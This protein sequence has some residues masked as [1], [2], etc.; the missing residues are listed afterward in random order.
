MQRHYLFALLAPAFWSISGVTVR[1]MESAD[2]WQIN[3]YR[4]ASLALFVFAVL[5]FRY[6]L[7][8]GDVLRSAGWYGLAAGSFV[9]LA[10]VCNI[11]ALTHTTVA[12]ATLLMATG[13]LVAALIG[14][15]VLAERPSRGTWVAIALAVV[16][17]LIMVGGNWHVG[18]WAGDLTA[19]VG[20][21]F[22]G[23]YAVTLRLGAMRSN[24]IPAIF[25]AGVF[26]MIVGG[27]MSL[28]TGAG[29]AVPLVDLGLCV[30]L[31]VVQIG[32][33]GLLF[34]SAAQTVPAV[35]LTLYA[36]IEP[37]LAPFW[38]WI[39]VGEVPTV[40]TFLAGVF[41]ITALIIHARSAAFVRT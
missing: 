11:F 27:G 28:W 37:V 13:P 9:G 38:T 31:G 4:S 36:L 2:H 12:N 29:L 14:R 22:F 7:R 33:G 41:L 10:M 35:D 24:M 21:I 8:Y 25:Y 3:C 6:R 30:M 20:V 15:W 34:V 39:G 32:V 16:G 19:L 17:I 18:S 1:L 23:C 40:S 5:L 26:G